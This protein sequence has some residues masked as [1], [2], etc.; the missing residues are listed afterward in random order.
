[1]FALAWLAGLAAAQ[2]PD[3]ARPKEP[4]K[5][6]PAIAAAVDRV[7]EQW[8]KS[9]PDFSDELIETVGQLVEFAGRPLHRDDRQRLLEIFT[10]IVLHGPVRPPT[11][12]APYRLAFDGLARLGEAGAERLIAIHER[13]RLPTKPDYRPLR[14]ALIEAIGRTRSERAAK[15]LVDFTRTA[16]EDPIFVAIG[17]AAAEFADAKQ[18][19]RKPLVE[20]LARRLAGFEN[21]ANRRPADP[22]RHRDLVA[23]DARHTLDALDGGWQRT[24]SA[25]TG[26][27]LPDGQAWWDWYQ[28]NKGEDWSRS[29][30]R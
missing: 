28:E 22:E 4:E 3:V 26:V 7:G 8:P 10:K 5:P 2:E 30:R 21:L 23:E 14:A 25:L 13:G 11:A 6:D 12:D 29:R 9:G 19:I 20:V 16:E 1:M 27:E 15:F 17:R 24:L 18:E